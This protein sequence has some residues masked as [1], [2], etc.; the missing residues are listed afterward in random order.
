M[1]I[2][3]G[4]TADT[5]DVGYV[6]GMCDAFAARYNE[7]TRN[8]SLRVVVDN[9]VRA[10]SGEDG[11]SYDVGDVRSDVENRG[12]IDERAIV[13][14]H[15]TART[16]HCVVFG[17]EYDVDGNY[18]VQSLRRNPR[19]TTR[20]DIRYTREPLNRGLVY[21]QHDETG[22]GRIQVFNVR[23]EGGKMIQSTAPGDIMTDLTPF[24]ALQ[25]LDTLVNGY[26]GDSLFDEARSGIR[27]QAN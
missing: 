20:L 19:S 24:E 2:L 11:I 7:L 13:G 17:L 3:G 16:G 23:D 5:T 4:R 9:M 15:L 8:G 10:S 12:T 18:V 6:V 26:L 21:A 1:D 22:E 27:R 25:C 14:V